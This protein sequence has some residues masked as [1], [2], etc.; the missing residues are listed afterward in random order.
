VVDLAKELVSS[1]TIYTLLITLQYSGLALLISWGLS[2]L[3]LFAKRKVIFSFF[4]FLWVLPGF[5]YALV[6]LSS[7]RW[8]GV[9]QRYS[10]LSVMLAWII[11]GTPYLTLTIENAIRDLDFRE[12]EALQTLGAGPLRSFYHF[13]FLRTF[14]AQGFALL[15]QFW[16][17]LTSFSLVMILSG[18]FPNE[19]LEVGIYTSIRLDHIDL[20]HAFALGI[21]QMLILIP[22]RF[23]L[24]CFKAVPQATEWTQKKAPNSFRSR[25]LILPLIIVMLIVV[26][27]LT[28]F[29]HL[30]ALDTSGMAG[31][32]YQSLALAILVSFS[33][34]FL[35]FALYYLKLGILAET[36]AWISPMLLTLLWWK[37]FGFVIL[38]FFNAFFVQVI[39][40]APWIARAL[41]PILKRVRVHEIE[42][43]RSLGCTCFQSWKLIEW[44]RIR[45]TVSFMASLVIALS[46]TE[47]TS[48]LLF[49]Q[50]NFQ[51]LSVWVQNSFMRFRLEEAGLGTC[52]LIAVSYLSLK[53]GQPQLKSRAGT[54]A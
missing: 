28:V 16:L 30:D 32:F 19:T 24:N 26:P 48:V 50:N 5:A 34:V 25:K 33:S 38:P 9:S 35:V 44:P 31:A 15:Q 29:S 7:L 17:Y 14:P 3:F 46:F 13:E 49:S 52:I 1:E 12:K 23:I 2:L 54:R 42:A 6:V 40:F 37:T 53:L 21:W 43:A 20:N 10:M 51:T 22:L 4:Q 45:E 8:M 47:V 27:L 11:A 18:G 39:L 41:Y 36:G